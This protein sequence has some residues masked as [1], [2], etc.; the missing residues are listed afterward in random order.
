VLRDDGD[1]VVAE[2]RR[3][4]RHHLVERRTQCVEVAAGVG[5][6][7]HGLL[8]CH[9]G[10][11]A[12]EH[13][14]L[15]E[16]RAIQRHRQPEVSELRCTVGSE[17]DV[18][19]LEVAVDDLVLVG[20]LESAAH[21]LGDGD[22]LVHRQPVQLGGTQ[23]IRERA[24]LEV[25]AHDEGLPVLLADVEDRNDVRVVA[26]AAHGLGLALHADAAL[27]VE[28][29]GLDERDGHVALE[30]GVVP[31]VDPLLRALTQEAAD[32]VAA[33][34]DAGRHGAGGRHRSD[35]SRGRGGGRHGGG[36]R[37]GRRA[38]RRRRAHRLPAVETE[39]CVAGQIP[40]AAGTARAEGSPALEAEAGLGRILVLAGST[41]HADRSRRELP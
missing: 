29:L 32:L 21:L 25:L 40:A 34:A 22:R 27:G 12:D 37:P 8:W 11:G 16:A 19:G 26:Q 13:P 23:S 6:A 30:P 41:S 31:Q 36:R 10:D 1:G 4:A 35:R 3:S 9:V 24:P 14:L 33:P 20:V 38:R 7:A 17:P 18:A 2:E 28:A 15:G 39:A 5:D